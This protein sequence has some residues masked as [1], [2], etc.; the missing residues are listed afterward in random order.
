M[1]TVRGFSLIE[2]IMIIVTLGVASVFLTTTFVQ[3]PRSQLLP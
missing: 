2:L 1:Q 3:L